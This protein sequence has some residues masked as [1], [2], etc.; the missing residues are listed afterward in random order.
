MPNSLGLLCSCATSGAM[1]TAIPQI[2]SPIL[3]LDP[4]KL[5]ARLCCLN[6][7]YIRMAKFQQYLIYS[8]L[9]SLL[10][11]SPPLPTAS[12]RPTCV[13][14]R[15]GHASI[16]ILTDPL[17]ILCDFIQHRAAHLAMERATFFTLKHPC[18]LIL[19]T[20]KTRTSGH[21]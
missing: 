8:R 19:A 11:P 14:T 6:S 4:H 12:V 13:A 3:R 9:Y 16:F 17:Q 20:Y 21:S 7:S 10:R 15:I 5:S 2:P 1:H 18:C